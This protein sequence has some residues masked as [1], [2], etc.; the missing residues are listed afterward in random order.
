MVVEQTKKAFSM[1]S[2]VMVLCSL[3]ACRSMPAK[4]AGEVLRE[5]V[6]GYMQAKIAKDW[7][8]V[9]DFFLPADMGDLSKEAFAERKRKVEVLRYTIQSVEIDDSGTDATV[10]VQYAVN[11]RSFEFKGLVDTQHWQLQDGQWYLR[12]DKQDEKSL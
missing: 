5:R 2:L 3:A 4:P 11:V 12:V 10:R 1:L 7:E 8:K 9:Y 6:D